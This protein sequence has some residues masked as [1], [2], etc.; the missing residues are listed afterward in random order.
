M[1]QCSL[2]GDAAVWFSRE[3]SRSILQSR[4]RFSATSI[5]AQ[6]WGYEMGMYL[7]FYSLLTKKQTRGRGAL[8]RPHI[9]LRYSL[10][11]PKRVAM[12]LY[13]RLRHKPCGKGS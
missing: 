13:T 6:C 3:M 5:Y 2:P 8:P 12:M 4:W 7:R 9:S 1:V 11:L 10:S